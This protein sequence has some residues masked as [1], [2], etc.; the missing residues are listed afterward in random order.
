M[1]TRRVIAFFASSMQCSA[2]PPM[3]TPTTSGGQGLPLA[4]STARSTKLTMPSRP[5]PGRRIVMRLMFSQ[6]PPLGM[7]LT[8]NA[9]PGTRSTWMTAGV[10]S[11]VF[12][13]A[14]NGCVTIDFRR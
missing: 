14:E 13:R 5:W 1:P 10:L 6:P 7:T 4:S 2:V 11:P 8:L 9:S 3:P 12:L